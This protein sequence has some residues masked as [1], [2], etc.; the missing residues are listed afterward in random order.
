MSEPDDLIDE[1]L[2]TSGR[3]R[4]HERWPDDVRALVA[5]CHERHNDTRDPA[6][7]KL[8]MTHV[9]RLVRERMQVEINVDHLRDWAEDCTEWGKWRHG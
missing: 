7:H 2:A 9:C 5:R 3:L 1:S 4:R 8:T 6:Y